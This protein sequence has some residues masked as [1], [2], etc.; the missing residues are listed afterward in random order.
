MNTR[1]PCKLIQSLSLIQNTLHLT[2]QFRQLPYS[3]SQQHLVAAMQHGS[4]KVRV[5]IMWNEIWVIFVSVTLPM[6]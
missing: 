1:F 5:G 2:S 4:L 6:G 3:V